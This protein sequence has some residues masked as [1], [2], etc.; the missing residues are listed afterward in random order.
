M[1]LLSSE[2]RTGL[3]ALAIT[4]VV[5]VANKSLRTL[6]NVIHQALRWW[7]GQWQRAISLASVVGNGLKNKGVEEASGAVE[8]VEKVEEESL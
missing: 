1:N 6:H 7:R 4:P 2:S 8:Q 5:L 3:E